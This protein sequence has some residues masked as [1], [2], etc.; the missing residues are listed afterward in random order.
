MGWFSKVRKVVSP[1]PEGVDSGIAQ[2]AALKI[3]WPLPKCTPA[4]MGGKLEDCDRALERVAARRK[5]YADYEPEW[6]RDHLMGWM[7][8]AESKIL[9]ERDDIK[10]GK[11]R[12]RQE[13]YKREKAEK[14]QRV[15]DVLKNLKLSNSQP[16]P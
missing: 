11:S 16:K 3:A 10:T 14:D 8:H 4:W 2:A 13:K 7:D 15:R 6:M 12:R 5:E 1:Y 9:E